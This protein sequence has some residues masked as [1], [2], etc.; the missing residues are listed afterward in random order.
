M[1]IH[2]TEPLFAWDELQDCPSLTTLKKLFES[3]PD[4]TLLNQLRRFRGRGRNDY[5]VE[6]LWGVLVLTIAL[7]HV[8]IEACL[9]ELQRN[10]ALRRLIGITSR[11]KV[12]R[13]G[14]C[15]D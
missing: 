15:P 6:V 11:T 12:P 7:R 10:E 14:T 4:A 3:L 8:T 5:P 13:L 1:R 9:A 2:I